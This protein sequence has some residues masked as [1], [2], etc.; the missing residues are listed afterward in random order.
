MELSSYFDIMKEN[1]HLRENEIKALNLE[2]E[3]KVLSRTKQIDEA[4]RE[5]EELNST[6]E[7]TNYEVEKSNSLLADEISEHQRV[8]T[9][10]TK[11]NEKLEDRVIHRTIELQ[12][13]NAQLA[14][15]NSLLETEIS[16]RIKVKKALQKSEELYRNVYENSPLAFG[17]S[18]KNFRF[19]DWNKR[20]EELFIWSKDD[21][22]GKRSSDFLVP[23]EI[24]LTVG[25][26]TKDLIDTGI[27]D[28]TLN[29]N[30]TKD[31]R[32]LFC[33]WHNSTLH[34]EDGNLNL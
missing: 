31:G 27:E 26:V 1:V 14:E 15:T 22:I 21:V 17:I 12:S 30:L 9:E 7:K 10:I 23:N 19:I 3:D 4:N 6:L 5:L 33:E 13:I 28:I 8:S 20:S 34:D 25:D 16:E 32:I 11:L 29:E 24:S 18:D 2:L